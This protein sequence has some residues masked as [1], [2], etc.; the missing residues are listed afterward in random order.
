MDNRLEIICERECHNVTHFKK[1]KRHDARWSRT[2]RRVTRNADTGDLLEDIDVR[3]KTDVELEQRLPPGVRNI[4]IR[5]LGW[6][7]ATA[8]PTDAKECEKAKRN[9]LKEQGIVAP[10]QACGFEPKRRQ[11][12]QAPFYFSRLI[13]FVRA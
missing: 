12:N 6:R 10:A 4:L 9:A 7:E 8:F 5:Y 11:L 3:N 2:I 1:L 13:E